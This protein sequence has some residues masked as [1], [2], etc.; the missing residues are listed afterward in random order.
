MYS[1]DSPQEAPVFLASNCAGEGPKITPLADNIF[2]AVY[3]HLAKVKTPVKFFS[4]ILTCFFLRSLN[5]I[6]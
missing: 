2:G 3:Q 4:L 5:F 1:R 6:N